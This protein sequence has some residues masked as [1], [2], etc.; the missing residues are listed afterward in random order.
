LN[1]TI[2]KGERVQF[3]CTRCGKCCSSGPNVALT[4]Y[5]VCRIAKHLGKSWRDLVGHVFYV[6]IADQIPVIVLRGVNN[7]CIFL[8]RTGGT[9]Y[10]EIYPARPMR[11]RLYPFVPIAPGVPH[12]MEISRNCPGV[13]LGQLIDPPWLD[14]DE[15][16]REVKSHYKLLFELI[17]EKGLDH[18]QALEV[19]LDTICAEQH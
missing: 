12:R 14:L 4:S 9:T 5:D 11:C 1:P 13:G 10:C 15:Y 16:I 19:L 17:F 8:R 18:L 6:V 2:V 3:T 7:V